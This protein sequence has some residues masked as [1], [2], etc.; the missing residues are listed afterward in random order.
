ML[1]GW[2]Y[3]LSKKLLEKQCLPMHFSANLAALA[4]SDWQRDA[5]ENYVTVD[6]GEVT[7]DELLWWRALLAPAPLDG[8]RL[9][10][11][12]RRGQ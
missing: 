10:A 11:N 2:A 1:A 8:G 7:L 4:N 5:D 12:S 9:L 3:V 6:I